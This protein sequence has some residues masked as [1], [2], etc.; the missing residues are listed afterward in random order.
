VAV[1]QGA[2]AAV[3]EA[4]TPQALQ[5]IELPEKE[6]RPRPSTAYVVV[7]RTELVP[8]DVGTPMVRPAQRHYTVVGVARGGRRGAMSAQ[9]SVS[10]DA[11]PAAPAQPSAV[12]REKGVELTWEPPRGMRGFAEE[13]PEGEA[14][15]TP[16][17][18][19]REDAPNT[20]GAKAGAAPTRTVRP[21]RSRSYLPWPTVR[22]GFNVY[23]VP[24]EKSD[25]S[26]ASPYA[27]SR[28]PQLLTSRP[29]AIAR[30]MD[31]GVTF[32]QERC[33]VVRTVETTGT[34][35]I[36]SPASPTACVKAADVFPPSPPRSLAAV[37]AE[38][39]INLIWEANKDAD[40]AGYLV[41]R[42]ADGAALEPQFTEPIPDTTWRDTSVK[43]GVKYRYAVVAV[44]NASP[45]NRST[46][47]NEVEASLR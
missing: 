43:P 27:A 41:L 29:L 9:V 7:R 23:A 33:Y 14:R 6:R 46:P 44:D 5:P 30:F 36:E 8:P 11:A 16:S 17:S 32:G 31:G 2:Q 39:S 22:S 26:D 38:Q 10:L 20:P 21:L 15:E 47:S 34:A 24:A 35:A 19:D 18:D 25:P 42:G 28:L 13:P 45:G 4:L 3:T 12:V 37:A 40:L 1:D